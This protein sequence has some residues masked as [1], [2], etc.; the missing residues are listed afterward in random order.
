MEIDAALSAFAGSETRVRL[1]AVL[2]N[3][4]HPLTG[5]RVAKTGMVSISKAYPEL[6]RLAESNLVIHTG[7]GWAIRDEDVAALLRK[8]VRIVD[9]GDWFRG[10]RRR[11]AEDRRLLSQLKNLPPPDWRGIGPK[12]IR[13]D[14]AR[15]REKDE[16]L[17]RHGMK[18]SVTHG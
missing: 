11:D 2:A 14:V 10:K 15:R 9:S 13:Y 12:T 1:L 17:V 6:R 8:R 3:A 7:R 18:P 16:L 5:Y 4:R